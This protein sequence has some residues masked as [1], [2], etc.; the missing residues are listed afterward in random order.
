M[1]A[2]LGS[3]MQ[4]AHRV[5]EKSFNQSSMISQA[6]TARREHTSMPSL[7]D[8]IIYDFP[9]KSAIFANNEAIHF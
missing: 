4:L 5:V 6:S 1:W 3:N 7:G 8:I 9:S 2:E